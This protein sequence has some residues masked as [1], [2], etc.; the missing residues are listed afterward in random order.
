MWWQ[1]ADLH[2]WFW[3]GERLTPHSPVTDPGLELSPCLEGDTDAASFS[4]DTCR[5]G[6][7]TVNLLLELEVFVH[8]ALDACLQM[9]VLSSLAPH[10][11]ERT[12]IDG[13]Q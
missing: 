8:E 12:V 9:H 1:K 5:V 4:L 10:L 13:D 11:C 2:G 3:V 7:E 6:L